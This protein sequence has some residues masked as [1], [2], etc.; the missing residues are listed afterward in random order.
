MVTADCAALVDEV[1]MVPFDAAWALLVTKGA[2]V[3]L[4]VVFL[5]S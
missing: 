1:E 5:A 4:V 2:G 3:R